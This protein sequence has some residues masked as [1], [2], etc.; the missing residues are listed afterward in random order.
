[1]KKRIGAATGG[2]TRKRGRK[3][4]RRCPCC[5]AAPCACEKSCFCQELKDEIEEDDSDETRCEEE[6]TFSFLRHGEQA[7]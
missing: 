2:E 3:G 1:M 6:L 4:V 7:V 5:G